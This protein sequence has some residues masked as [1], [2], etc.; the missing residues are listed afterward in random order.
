MFTLYKGW[1]NFKFVRL[2]RCFLCLPIGVFLLLAQAV[3]LA[4]TDRAA[5]ISFY[6]STGGDVSWDDKSGWKAAP[7]LADGF[8]SDPCAVPFWFGV[9]CEEV[10]MTYHLVQSEP[11]PSRV[12]R[13]E[14][15]ENQVTGPWW[16]SEWEQLSELHDP[17]FI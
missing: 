6:N 17:G 4:E 16:I 5:L 10:G 14:L 8:N 11:G 7:T 13:L 2:A 15:R 12:T 3:V 9:T 1:N